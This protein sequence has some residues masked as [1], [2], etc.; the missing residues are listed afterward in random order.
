VQREAMATVNVLEHRPDLIKLFPH[1]MAVL[2]SVIAIM[3]AEN[4]EHKA[5]V[6]GGAASAST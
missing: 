4:A 3:S 6:A 2:G 5:R 1:L